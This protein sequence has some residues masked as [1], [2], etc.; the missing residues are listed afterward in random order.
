MGGGSKFAVFISILFV[1]VVIVF[2]VFAFIVI[3]F[4]VPGGTGWGEGGEREA[5][6][7]WSP[8]H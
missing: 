3:D 1:V 7:V 6:Q 8:G 4:L 2:V 5:R